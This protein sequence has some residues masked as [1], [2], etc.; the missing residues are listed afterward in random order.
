MYGQRAAE[1]L[2][3]A[4]PEG[5]LEVQVQAGDQTVVIVKPEAIVDV[6]RFLHDDEELSFTYLSDLTATDLLGNEPRFRVI[7]H[8][9]SIERN[10][11][12]R[13]RVPVYSTSS[14][15]EAFDGLPEATV[16]GRPYGEGPC[17]P[18]VTAIWRGANWLEREVYDM[19]GI[20]FAGHPDLRRI[21]MPDDWDGHPLRKDYPL[22]GTAEEPVL[23]FEDARDVLK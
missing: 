16:E 2:K 17:V 1:K 19:F 8:L 9:Y 14:V 7:Y 10:D 3:E 5:I 22:L 6:C 21:L 23:L 20:V 15:G 12:L 18:S 13:I 4:F 11:W